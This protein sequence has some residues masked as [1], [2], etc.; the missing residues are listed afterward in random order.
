[1]NLHKLYLTENE[2]YKFGVDRP[3]KGIMVHST[4]ANNPWLSRYVGPDD[5]LL[6]VNKYG[7]HWNQARP[8]GIQVCVNAFIGKLKDGT[9]ATYQTLPWTYKS[10]HSGTGS[11]G[12]SNNANNNGYL[13]FEICEDGLNDKNY[14]NAIYKEAT[15]L[16]A[17]LCK[18]YKLDPTKKGVVIC[19]SEG[20]QMGIAS[21]HGDIMHWWPKFGKNM[22]TFRTDVAKLIGISSN[23]STVT[24][25][26]DTSTNC[27]KVGDVV[28]FNGTKHYRS[29]DA[30]T[31]YTC[32]P[33]KAKITNISTIK[34][35]KHPYCLK[36]VNGGGSTVYGWV[37]A[38]DVK[39][40]SSFKPY[41]AKVTASVLNVREKA[42]ASS[43][44]TT[45]IKKNQ[46]Y[47]IIEENNGWG[48]LKSGAGWVSLQYM[49][50]IR[51]V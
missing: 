9:V 29:S 14:F 37:D 12:S 19:H 3:I 10:W 42:S 39:A 17:Y 43:K 31:A 32:K 23:T 1:M 27:F 49:S 50:K 8:D 36:Y 46:I 28:Q 7:N 2:C 45:T 26:K 15:E 33:G 47:T 11:L 4:G 24:S 13:G 22:D 34:N 35:I 44:V 16:V 38:N 40:I 30:A 5:G 18:T 41:L 48:R 20:H 21:N 51:N 6:G 25:P